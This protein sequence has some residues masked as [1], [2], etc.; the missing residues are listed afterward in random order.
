MP[1]MLICGMT[2]SGKTTYATGLS[3]GYRKQGIKS[4]V[5]DPLKDKRWGADF[6][7]DDIDLFLK[8]AQN[9]LTYGCA[10]F[11]DESGEAMDKFNRDSSHW[12]ATRGR[13]KGHNCHFICQKITQVAPIVRDQC[14]YLVMFQIGPT[15][16]KQLA[17][18]W[19]RPEIADI[20]L[21]KGQFIL[22]PRFGELEQGEVF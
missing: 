10:V 1:H 11:I 14:T 22:V 7:T 9:D 6:L 5:L 12:L 8:V 13:H 20:D 16:R 4:I 19:N 2:E 17:E 18:E 15:S 3:Q 21:K